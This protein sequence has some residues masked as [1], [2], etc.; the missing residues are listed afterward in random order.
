MVAVKKYVK[1]LFEVIHRFMLYVIFMPRPNPH[2][3]I[4]LNAKELLAQGRRHIW[5]LSGSNGIWT[6]SHLVNEHST[7]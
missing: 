5:S 1:H 4:C 2:S 6:H 7:N 3:I